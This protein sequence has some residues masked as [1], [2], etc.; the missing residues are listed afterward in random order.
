MLL[1]RP[2][3]GEAEGRWDTAA[4]NRSK[5]DGEDR[6][7]D[8]NP[9][10]EGASKRGRGETG[11]AGG[12]SLP[13]TLNHLRLSPSCAPRRPPARHAIE[14]V[15]D[16]STPATPLTFFTFSTWLRLFLLRGAYVPCLPSAVSR[17][18]PPAR[19]FPSRTRVEELTPSPLPFRTLISPPS[20]CRQVLLGPPH[21]GLPPH[22]HPA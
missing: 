18:P 13:L 7:C 14:R 6:N 16:S 2:L 4:E 11:W 10:V 9:T 5:P 15:S 21:Q 12:R 19:F 1:K 8:R 3:Q 20:G 22:R 17:P